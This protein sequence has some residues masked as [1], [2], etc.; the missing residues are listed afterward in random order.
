[1]LSTSE[2]GG[3]GLI[4]LADGRD[5]SV[6]P[7]LASAIEG[8]WSD[9]AVQVMIL[10]DPAKQVTVGADLAKARAM[11]TPGGLPE[12][13]RDTVPV[14]SLERII[15]NLAR[16]VRAAC[17]SDEV[18]G[19]TD[20][21]VAA[22]PLRRLAVVGAGTMGASIAHA[23]AAA[24]CE[25]LLKDVDQQ[26]LDRGLEILRELAATP[27]GPVHPD[28]AEAAATLARVTPQLGFEGFDDLDLVV[29]SV[30]EVIELKKMLF[31]ELDSRCAPR[32]ILASNTSSL[33]I[34][35]MATATTRPHKV[36][37]H[38]FFHPVGERPLMEIGRTFVTDVETLVSSIAAAR[39]IGKTPIVVPDVTGFLANR[40][41]AP[42]W[43]E[44][45]LLV[46]EGAEPER[47]DR[48]ALAVG[49]SIGP[50]H[51]V[52]MVGHDV[53]FLAGEVMREEL[54]RIVEYPAHASML[55]ER[56]RLGVK[57]G[58]GYYR[59]Q[60]PDPTPIPDPEIEEILEEARQERGICR[61]DDISDAEIYERL[62]LPTI[63]HGADALADNI[64]V[65]AADI[66]VAMVIGY[67][68]PA[69][70]GGPMCA[71]D[72]WGLET[73][74]EKLLGYER[75]FGRRFTPSPYLVELAE[76]GAGFYEI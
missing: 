20:Q 34:A 47:V 22:L 25:V 4:E 68:S 50:L 38:H 40:I 9:A 7:E 65:S 13:L 44:A 42:G 61:R 31:A 14:L 11:T 6:T 56:G 55:H 51:A 45:R 3:F 19:V 59:Y 62:V 29:E 2:Q 32:T 67:G 48:L 26:A 54:E 53:A 57:S 8:F 33:S 16:L 43:L 52:D 72:H 41:P 35:Y 46:E 5:L 27:V 60:A 36:V 69:F 30:P 74:V 75:R 73:I 1:M 12:G 37:G 23:Y 15:S 76:A 21:G 63:N 10:T 18:P 58:A 39:L 64:A 66:D 70:L 71:A 17:R 24:G 28:P 49:Q